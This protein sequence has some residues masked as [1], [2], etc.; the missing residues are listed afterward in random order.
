MELVIFIV[1]LLEI[2]SLRHFA[3]CVLYSNDFAVELS[4]NQSVATQVAKEHGFYVNSK[5]CVSESF[6]KTITSHLFLLFN[7]FIQ[8]KQ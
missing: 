6:E 5:V 1:F 4:S 2:I 8:A 3:V 7:H